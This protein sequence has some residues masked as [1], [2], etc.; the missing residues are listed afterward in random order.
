MS[1]SCLPQKITI[2]ETTLRDGLQEL[3]VAIPTYIKIAFGE[4]LILTGGVRKIE[5][6]N[7]G[8]KKG[9]KQFADQ[10]DVLAHFSG[11][12]FRKKCLRKGINE[13]EL[14]FIAVTVSE[15]SVKKALRLKA[16]GVGPDEI[17]LTTFVDEAIQIKN[18]GLNHK[19]YWEMAEK[20]IKLCH[21]AGIKVTGRLAIDLASESDFKININEFT[22]RW[23]DIGADQVCHADHSGRATVEKI[24]KYFGM[25][26]NEVPDPG[27]HIAHFHQ[28]AS[29]PFGILS[30]YGALQEG[31]SQ[32]ELSLLGLGGQPT[33][34]IDGHPIAGTGKYAYDGEYVGMVPLESVLQL[35]DTLDIQHGLDSEYIQYLAKMLQQDTLQRLN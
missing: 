30:L 15:N 25:V 14:T 19:Q 5:I 24:K 6:T 21:D 4:A 35:M 26:L 8:S 20:Y 1:T 10:E 3:T 9:M 13:K 22:L 33:N 2:I 11:D 28:R 12:E 17:G 34:F 16:D 23:F 18:S 29:T 31:V 27:K 32:F 7:L